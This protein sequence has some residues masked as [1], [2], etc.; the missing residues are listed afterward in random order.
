MA[1]DQAPLEKTPSASGTSK[2]AEIAASSTT[3][4]AEFSTDVLKV[5]T[6]NPY[7]T[8]HS[9]HPGLVLISKPLT[10][11]NYSTWKRAMTLALNSKKKLGFVNGSIKTP[12]ER[13]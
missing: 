4:S 13:N 3:K 2:S 6:S 12:S 8:H 1:N 9:D 10:G 5:D 11:D 7:F